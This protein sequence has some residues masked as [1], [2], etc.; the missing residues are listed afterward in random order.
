MARAL[1]MA[2]HLVNTFFLLAALTVTAYA[3]SGGQ[4][5]APGAS[6]WLAAAFAAVMAGFAVA[7]ASGAVAAL[8]DTLFPAGSIQEA[9]AQDLSPTAH[10]LVRLRVFH[11]ALAIAAGLLGAALAR[12]AARIRPEPS[13]L[14]LAIAIVG[15]VVVQLVA[16]FVNVML[17]APV[18]LQLVHLLFA[19]LLWI[20]LV[21]LAAHTL[22]PPHAVVAGRRLSAV[23]AG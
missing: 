2:V 3:A 4:A 13:I 14:R 17:L 18:W 15:L 1:F 20:L 9:L 19:D 6:P 8:G 7:G 12:H 16:G 21:L 10:L 5:P 23:H 11:P 22:A